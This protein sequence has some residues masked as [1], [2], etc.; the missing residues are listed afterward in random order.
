[1]SPTDPTSAVSEAGPEAPPSAP[2]RTLPSWARTEPRSDQRRSRWKRCPARRSGRMR[3]YCSA[4]SA[5]GRLTSRCMAASSPRA[6]AFRNWLATG[7]GLARRP[8]RT[9]AAPVPPAATSTSAMT[10]A[11]THERDRRTAQPPIPRPARVRTGD[12]MLSHTHLG[13]GPQLAAQVGDLVAEP[14]RVLEAQ[15]L[16]GLVHL[17][18]ERGDEPH[19]VVLWHPADR[20]LPPAAPAAAARRGRGAALARAAA[21]RRALLLAAQRLDDVGDPLAHRLRVDAVGLVVLDLEL[22]APVGLADGAAHRRRDPA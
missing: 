12:E 3:R 2:A 19:Q 11:M 4:K 9:S 16:G 14:G 20:R 6:Q 22:A 13:H 5:G 15:V 10:R 8:G 17:L 7:S 21:R 1:M 18:L